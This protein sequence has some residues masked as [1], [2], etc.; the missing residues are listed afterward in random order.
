MTLE[1]E[2]L[3][4]ADAAYQEAKGEN[5][6]FWTL[7]DD[8]PEVKYWKEIWIKGYNAA[9][10][11]A[12]ERIEKARADGYNIGYDDGI[13]QRPKVNLKENGLL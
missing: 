9:A 1:Q 2:I 10:K 7:P 4:A 6:N 5:V 13:N 3:Q 11:I 12:R 8:D